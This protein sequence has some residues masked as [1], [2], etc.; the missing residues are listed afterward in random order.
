MISIIEAKAFLKD[1]FIR[2]RDNENK[3]NPVLRES[4]RKNP[5]PKEKVKKK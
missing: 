4:I 3:K 2:M 1:I 5:E